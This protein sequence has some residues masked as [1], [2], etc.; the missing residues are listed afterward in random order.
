MSIDLGKLTLDDIESIASRL[1]AAARVFREARAML[2]GGAAPSPGVVAQPAQAPSLD[3]A[4]VAR[5]QQLLSQ[6]PREVLE[7]AA[8]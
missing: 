3:A 4:E 7:A 2:G 8:K 6:F 5:R 1:E